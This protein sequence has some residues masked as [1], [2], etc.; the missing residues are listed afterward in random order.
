MQS[1]AVQEQVLN[2]NRDFVVKH[3]DA[4][5]V[6]D[7]LIQERIIGRSAAQ[8]IQLSGTSRSEKNRI[9]CD[10]LTTAGPDSV[11]KFC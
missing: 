1:L 11:E 9:I 4:D 6:I 7:E 2:E 8:Q 3:L 5:E 10:Q